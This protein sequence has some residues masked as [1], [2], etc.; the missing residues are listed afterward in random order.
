VSISSK[1]EGLLTFEGAFF[2]ARVVFF[3]ADVAMAKCST[4]SKSA[5]LSTALASHRLLIGVFS[6]ADRLNHMTQ[7]TWLITGGAGYI[8]THIADEFI[9]AGI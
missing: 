1:R 3:F 5:T 6:C 4:K 9:R 7:E 8:G 2:T